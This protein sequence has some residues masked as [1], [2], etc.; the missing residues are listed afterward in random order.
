MMFRECDPQL[1]VGTGG[2][3]SA[4]AMAWAV[5]S[6]RKTALQEQNAMPGMVTRLFAPRVDQL[7]LGYPEAWGR[8]NPGAATAVFDLGNPVSPEPAADPY[9]WP[10]GLIVVVM[11]GSQGALGLNDR[12]LTGLQATRDW[13]PDVTLVWIAGP[14]HQES[15]AA[16]IRDAGWADRVRVVPFI[17]DLGAQ[18]HN[19]TLAVSRSGAMT[20]A[21]LAVAGIPAILV[22]LPSA[23]EDHQRFNARALADAGAALLREEA[24]VGA[25]LWAIALDLL[26]DRERLGRM[27]RSMSAR[28]RPD[29]ADHIASELLR[30]LPDEGVARDV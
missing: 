15:V 18:L 7:H 16:R 9:A 1:V 5:A 22:P 29:A 6:G 12:L 30:L 21:E 13:P 17:Q 24:D 14:A 27:A 26:R 28:G 10:E 23:A 4:P 3:A 25:E 20:C 2:Y 11:G 8:L 19:V